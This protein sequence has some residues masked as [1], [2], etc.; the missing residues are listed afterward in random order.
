MSA[1]RKSRKL[2]EKSSAVVESSSDE[3][4][5]SP[6]KTRTT[7]Q[8]AVKK[9]SNPDPMDPEFIKAYDAEYVKFCK[10]VEGVT[11]LSSLKDAVITLVKD[12]K[13]GMPVPRIV[14]TNGVN[15]LPPAN[16]DRDGASTGLS[17]VGTFMTP[18]VML[19]GAYGNI[20]TEIEKNNRHN[21]RSP[22][23]GKPHFKRDVSRLK[24]TI[25][26]APQMF[27]DEPLGESYKHVRGGVDVLYRLANAV[28]PAACNGVPVLPPNA[29]QRSYDRFKS[30]PTNA[31]K[32]EDFEFDVVA[33]ANNPSEA[34]YLPT[35]VKRPDDDDYMEGRTHFKIWTYVFHR[36]KDTDPK[37][38]AS[39]ID[40]HSME[41]CKAMG[42]RADTIVEV[43]RANPDKKLCLVPVYDEKDQMVPPEKY[44]DA[45][46]DLGGLGASARLQVQVS[47]VRGQKGG[48]QYQCYLQAVYIYKRKPREASGGSS[49][50]AVGGIAGMLMRASR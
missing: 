39:G 41:L 30:D 13:T 15:L 21:E 43:L 4:G 16:A 24:T 8:E 50:C 7:V 3:D 38:P 6:K 34:P 25:R 20:V 45:W 49:A 47:I 48:V 40:K 26:I 19:D 29:L 10:G 22:E 27:D 14:D 23:P 17:K 18:P 28:V 12:P 11:H 9:P 44:L 37:D 35:T 42:P 1:K 36:R 31:S 5:P 33:L 2:L 46:D 32:K